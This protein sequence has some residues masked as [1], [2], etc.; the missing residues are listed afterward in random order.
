[1]WERAHP[2]VTAP[3]HCQ[4]R[5]GWFPHPAVIRAGSAAKWSETAELCWLSTTCPLTCLSVSDWNQP[6]RWEGSPGTAPR[7][8]RRD[9][10]PACRWA[11]EAPRPHCPCLLANADGSWSNNRS[12]RENRRGG[13][14]PGSWASLCQ[15]LPKLAAHCD[16]T[17]CCTQRLLLSASSLS[18]QDSWGFGQPNLICWEQ[19]W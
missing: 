3:T 1:M 9:W 12:D 7:K 15:P 6:G 10:R 14:Q 4:V 8:R 19:C 11:R 13:G 16:S 2:P 18:T 5:A 17:A